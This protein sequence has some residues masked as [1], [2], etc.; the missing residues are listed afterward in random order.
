MC[1][2]CACVR[3]RECNKTVVVAQG[4]CLIC[5]FLA[6]FFHLPFFAFFVR[7]RPGICV[8]C[9]ITGPPSLLEAFDAMVPHVSSPSAHRYM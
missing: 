2:W 6:F 7:N 5:P 4:I 9:F 8:L 3:E 1:V